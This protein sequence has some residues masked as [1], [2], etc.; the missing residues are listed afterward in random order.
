MNAW[1]T[2]L[3]LLVE[4]VSLG[5][6]A[7]LGA[8]HA[9]P[10]AAELLAHPL[11]L[12]P[13]GALR[14]VSI[15]DVGLGAAAAIYAFDG[16]GAVVYIGEEIKDAARRMAP[17]VFWA[18]G[19]AAAFQLVPVLAVLAGAPSLA[20]LLAAPTPL[21][22]FMRTVGGS[23]LERAMSLGV[24]LALVNAM[25]ASALM[26]GR[27]LYSSG[28]DRAWPRRLSQAFTALHP[29]FA[30][31]W[32]ATLTLGAT[33]LVWCLVKLGVLVILIGD[34]TAAIYVCMCLAALRGR[35]S[36]PPSPYQMPGFPALP[37]LALA[38]LLAVGLAD[39][40]DP[41]GRQG[42]FASA[43]TVAIAVLYYRLV[44]RRRGGW[45]HR[46][47]TTGAA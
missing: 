8:S 32:V 11:T 19:L 12:A 28:R 23:G 13:G 42:V 6:V 10:S 26:G 39:L 24:A 15:A 27:Q 44:V 38:A 29:R 41:V 22:E 21:L 40:F 31:P 45:A 35:G 4:L 1:V 16:Y 30:S 9:R 46:G 18:L 33:S 47:P 34:G 36:T 37:L 3:F 5:A 7:W 14:P 43:L 2:G 20:R 17:V 25:I